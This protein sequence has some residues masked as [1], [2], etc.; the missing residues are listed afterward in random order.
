YTNPLDAYVLHTVTGLTVSVNPDTLFIQG[1]SYLTLK[2]DTVDSNATNVEIWRKNPDNSYAVRATLSSSSTTFDDSTVLPNK[3]YIYWIY[4]LRKDDTNI[5][6]DNSLYSAT[7]SKLT[8]PAPPT[9]FQ[10]NGIDKTIYMSWSHTKDCDGYKIYKWV[11]SG[12]FISWSL[13]ETIGKNTLS[14]HI[15]VADYGAYSFKVTAYNASGDSAQSP[16]KDAYA[17]MAPTGLLATPLSSTSIKL[18]W[19]ALDTN[20]TQVRVSYSTNGTVYNSLGVF[21]MPVSYI[22]AS[23]L[24]PN[25]QYW[26]KIAVKRDSNESNYSDF[27]TAK[28]LPVGTTPAKPYGFGGVA[29]TCN[30]VDLVWVDGSDNEDGFKIERKE[31]AG[32][33]AEIGTVPANTISYSDTAIS[34]GKT[35]YYRVRAYNAYGNSDYTVEINITIPSCDSDIYST[36]MITV[37]GTMSCDLDLGKQVGSTDP[38]IDFFWEQVSGVERY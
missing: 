33:Y 25:T 24:T 11:H 14:Y 35:Y 8:L 29:L 30:K 18:T 10:A 26:F 15:A 36:G 6:N 20:A 22:T 38:P 27:A 3:T 19:N 5:H 21:N 13:I 17:L 1:N 34:T 28:T 4:A 23:S 7:V 9:N 2:W 12:I 16:T 37:R 31:G 32:A